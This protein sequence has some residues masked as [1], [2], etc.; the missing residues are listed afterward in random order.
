MRIIFVGASGHGK[1]CAEIAGLNGYND[2]LFLD[3]NRELKEC[4]GYPVEGV[5]ADFEKYVDDSTYFFVSIGNGKTRKRIQ[6]EIEAAKGNI[7]TLIHPKSI[8]S[9]DVQ[10]GI[11]SVIMAGAVI[12]PGTVIGKGVIVNTSSSIDHDCTINSYSHIAVGSHICGFVHIGTNTWVGAGATISNH[13]SICDDCTIGA[14]ALV[15]H[16]ITSPDTYVGVPVK[17]IG[18][19]SQ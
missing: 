12:N 13:L 18:G 11:D 9:K 17:R 19:I 6:E 3:D 15:I 2:I 4:A 5:K 10:I 16:D 7:A 8:V 14:G 1:V